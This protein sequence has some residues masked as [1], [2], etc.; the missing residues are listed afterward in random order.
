MNELNGL[1]LMEWG[2]KMPRILGHRFKDILSFE[3]SHLHNFYAEPQKL[4][5]M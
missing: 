5:I 3:M 2:Y 1:V 4:K